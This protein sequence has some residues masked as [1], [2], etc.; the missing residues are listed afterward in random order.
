SA[1]SIAAGANS[2]GIYF[3][4]SKSGAPTLTASAAG[5]AN[6]TQVETLT[7]GAAARL[8]LVSSPQTLVAGTCSAAVT[9]QTQDT[10]GNSTTVGAATAVALAST[11]AG[12]GFFTDA[13]CTVA[14]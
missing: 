6:G 2:T 8:A 1:M 9:V 10:F 11:S 5:F 13:G 3:K 4:D 7:P 12:N 14:S